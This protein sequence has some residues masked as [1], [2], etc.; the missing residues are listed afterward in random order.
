VLSQGR[1]E[2]A[3]RVS[4]DASDAANDVEM[5]ITSRI[6]TARRESL[7][8]SDAEFNRLRRLD[9][10]A[11]IQSFL[12]A[13][14]INAEPDGETLLSVRSVLAQ[15]R[16][17]CMEGAMVA[18]CALWIHGLPP[19]LMHLGSSGRDYPHVVALFRQG[20]RWGAI[21]KSNGIALRFRDPVYV[22][23]RELAMS[24]FH[25][26]SDRHGNKTLRSFSRAFD[27]RRIPVADWVTQRNDCWAAHDALEASRHH[28]LIRGAAERSLARRDEFER[29]VAAIGQYP[30]K[31]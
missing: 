18:A 12:N 8:L 25:E 3:R 23:L 1:R 21:S 31:G 26:Y 9:S 6:S 20:R 14:P 16:A 13:I 4:F 15:R 28:A 29:A 17:H 22:T 30:D 27:L 7:G 5:T 19:L 11:R 10:P 24:Y 2:T